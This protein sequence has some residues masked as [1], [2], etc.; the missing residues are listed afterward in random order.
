[1]IVPPKD[2]PIIVTK[3]SMKG[4][5]AGILTVILVIS[6]FGSVFAIMYAGSQVLDMQNQRITNLGTP[7]ASTDASTKAYVD[8]LA[9]I[10][11][12]SGIFGGSGADGSYTCSTTSCP[13]LNLSQIYQF[14]D[15]TV[16]SGAILNTTFKSGITSR[17]G[18]W[19]IANGTCTIAGVINVS[20]RGAPAQ[21]GS[22]LGGGVDGSGNDG[23]AS[24]ASGGGGGT[25][26][27]GDGLGTGG[28]A[29]A[30]S[31]NSTLFAVRLAGAAGSSGSGNPGTPG[32]PGN[33]ASAQ[34][35]AVMALHD[36]N[37]F[38]NPYLMT[39]Y[40]AGGGG[41]GGL[42]GGVI[43]LECM[44]WNFTGRMNASGYNGTSVAGGGT[45]NL[46]GGAGGTGIGQAGSG[47]A[48]ASC[49]SGTGG[50]GGGGGG[51][52]IVIYKTLVANSGT[53]NVNGGRGGNAWQLTAG[54]TTCG[55]GGGGASGYYKVRKW[56][57]Q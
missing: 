55:S 26:A 8:S 9:S 6:L 16:S 7:T 45:T 53:I 38:R 25:G 4:F 1:M 27:G 19:V 37:A 51:T 50:S 49:N 12:T 33:A 30:E 28:Y 21:G 32:D 42:G 18:L 3:K 15:F 36:A 23:D 17:G 34:A 11:D 5:F 10:S 13:I 20:G 52:V 14:T 40:G 41:T 35:Y 56:V 44:S 54:G 43:Y 46:T 29:A 39:S 22:G 31:T 24:T 48:S 47:G 57:S 2:E